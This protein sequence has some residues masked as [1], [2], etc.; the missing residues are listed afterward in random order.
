MESL[1]S[2]IMDGSNDPNERGEMAGQHD[3]WRAA[4]APHGLPAGLFL[5][6]VEQSSIAISITDPRAHI[7]FSNPAFSQLTGYSRGELRG[8]NH[9]VL[10]SQQTPRAEGVGVVA[11]AIRPCGRRSVNSDPGVAG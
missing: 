7:V 1:V 5:E 10:A 11:D 2:T 4:G 3:V 9:N 8:R 6:V